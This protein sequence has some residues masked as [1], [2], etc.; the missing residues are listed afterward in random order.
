MP[1]ITIEAA[2]LSAE[3][4]LELIQK[5]PREASR[6]MNVPVDEFRVFIR[7]LPPENIGVGDVPLTEIF[8]ARGK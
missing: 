4:K 6:I 3:Q 1:L 5:M 2:A 8:K 7:E